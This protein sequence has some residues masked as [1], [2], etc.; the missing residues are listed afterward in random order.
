MSDAAW[1]VNEAARLTARLKEDRISEQ[2]LVDALSRLQATSPSR[3]AFA[4]CFSH[5]KTPSS[6]AE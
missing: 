4:V 3:V 5:H 6:P 2:N 1:V